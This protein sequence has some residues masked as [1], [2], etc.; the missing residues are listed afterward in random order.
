MD[1]LDITSSTD[2]TALQLHIA[3]LQSLVRALE[4][5]RAT[6]KQ[7]GEQLSARYASL[8]SKLARLNALYQPLQETVI[9]LDNEN[10][11][12]KLEKTRWL[13]EKR[14]TTDFD[15][16]RYLSSDD[17]MALAP[18]TSTEPIKGRDVIPFFLLD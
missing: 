8:Q 1:L 16:S 13:H 17:F 2:T 10:A 5:A 7:H 3:K 12:L 11:Q 6:D 4:A 18:R 15:T 9:R 14:P